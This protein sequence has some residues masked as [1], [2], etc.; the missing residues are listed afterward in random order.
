M[1]NFLEIRTV[2]K[3][4]EGIMIGEIKHILLLLLP[5]CDVRKSNHRTDDPAVSDLRMG[6]VLYGKCRS[7]FSDEHLVLT[8]DGFPFGDGVIDSALFFRIRRSILSLM[9]NHLM[10]VFA[11]EI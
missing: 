10:A 6:R 7:I 2:V 9:M 4:C 1:V 5:F 11:D 3:P 8:S